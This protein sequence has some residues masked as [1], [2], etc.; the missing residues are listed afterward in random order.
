[1][2]HK[3]KEQTFFVLTGS[4]TVTVDDE[5][6][7]VNP[8]DIVFIPLNTPHTTETKDDDLTYFCLNTYIMETQDNSFEEMYNRIAPGRIERWKK[9]DT[10]VGN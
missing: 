10:S 8:G 2:A 4:G 5:N 1:M 9:G 3:E 7:I 6:A